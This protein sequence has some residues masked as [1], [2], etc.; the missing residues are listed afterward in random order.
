MTPE[1]IA[2]KLTPAQRRALLWLSP[3]ADVRCGGIFERGQQTALRSV[4]RRGLAE[5]VFLPSRRGQD[6][7]YSITP[8]GAAVRAILAKE[9]GDA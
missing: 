8:L 1:E 4:R 3:N 6:A 7:H 9:A 5:M 2:K